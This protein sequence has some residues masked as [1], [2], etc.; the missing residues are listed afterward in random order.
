RQSTIRGASSLG[1][2]STSSSTSA[3]SRAA[4]RRGFRRLSGFA[5]VT[6]T[7]ALVASVCTQAMAA[8]AT[9]TTPADTPASVLS[10]REQ[11][12]KAGILIGSGS[13]NP[14]YLDEPQFAAVAAEQFN[15]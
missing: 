6:T 10:L 9:P 15:S 3:R 14:D 5:I 1:T 4:H 12:A 11:A 7:L 8:S 2:P 13:I